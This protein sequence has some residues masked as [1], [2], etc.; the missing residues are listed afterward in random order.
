M[1]LCLMH[2]GFIK[3]DIQFLIKI[4]IEQ[5]YGKNRLKNKDSRPFLLKRSTVDPKKQQL[6]KS[7]TIA[8]LLTLI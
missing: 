1:V 6:Q 2:V 8:R 7:K 5:L 4:Q 3:N